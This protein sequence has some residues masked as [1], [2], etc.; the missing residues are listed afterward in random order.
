MPN[1]MLGRLVLYSAV[2][3]SA[4]LGPLAAHAQAL[5]YPNKPVKVII[6]AGPGDSCDL[7][8][9]LIGPK[10]TEK[11]GQ[12]WVIENRPGSTGQLGLNLIKQ[13]QPD[14]YTLG[15]GQGG[16]MVIVPLAYEKVSYDTVKDFAPVALVAS[17][18][19]ALVVH[20]DVP[21]KT[22]EDLINYAKANP[23]KVTF[24][25]NG[26]GGFLHFA[27]E[28]FSRHAGFSY[29]HVPYKT[30]SASMTEILGG[31]INASLT[32]FNA[33]QPFVSSGKV[34]VLALARTTRSPDYPQVPTLS[35]AVPGFTSGGWFGVIA[36]AGTPKEIIASINRDIIAALK[37]PDVR[38]RMKAYGLEIHTELPEFFSETIRSDFIKWGKLTKDMGFKPM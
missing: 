4:P 1:H 18:F 31:Q 33:V 20:P 7:M 3:L 14:G 11:T 36:P 22:T 13:A 12:P 21:F 6:P 38:L 30:V 8:M 35:E 16:N 9:R 19:L 32:S 29:L 2:L 26:E 24:G 17:N 25:T 5:P 23:G 10:I 37:L 34:R 27:T 15:C 28:L